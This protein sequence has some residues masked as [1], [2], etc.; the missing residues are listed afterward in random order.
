MIKKFLKKKCS[1]KI[2]PT[3]YNKINKN[4]NNIN[5]YQYQKIEYKN[6]KLNFKNNNSINK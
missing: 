3:I 2:Y 6:K 1:M 5:S 4:N